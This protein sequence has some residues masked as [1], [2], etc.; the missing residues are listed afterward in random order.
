MRKSRER[1]ELAFGKETIY[2]SPS[3]ERAEALLAGQ[4]YVVTYFAN[5]MDLRATVRGA[6]LRCG[7]QEPDV[8]L[9]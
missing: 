2:L 7:C 6:A 3:L 1:E 4:G 5:A 9:A 8:G